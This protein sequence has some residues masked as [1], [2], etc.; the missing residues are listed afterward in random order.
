MC[1][2]RIGDCVHR[3]TRATPVAGWLACRRCKKCAAQ[4]KQGVQLTSSRSSGK[5]PGLASTTGGWGVGGPA[6]PCP[7]FVFSRCALHT[8]PRLGAPRALGREAKSSPGCGRISGCAATGPSGKAS[9]H[10]GPARRSPGSQERAQ[11]GLGRSARGGGGASGL[12]TP[13]ISRARRRRRGLRLLLGV[14]QLHLSVCLPCVTGLPPGS[15]WQ[16]QSCHAARRRACAPKD[17]KGGDS[18][19][20]VKN[21]QR[22]SSV[23]L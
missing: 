2:W 15:C 22:V 14:L 12:G 9:G 17:A 7:R 19:F 5:W 16:W 3:G 8:G 20:V 13:P 1:G 11:W 6:T 4:S 18:G 23:S 21:I 10:R